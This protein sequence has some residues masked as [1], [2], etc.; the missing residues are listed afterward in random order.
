MN[1]EQLKNLKTEDF[2]APNPVLC[3]SGGTFQGVAAMLSHGVNIVGIIGAGRQE[4]I[5]IERWEL[6]CLSFAQAIERYGTGGIV[7]MTGVSEGV[8]QKVKDDLIDHGFEKNKIF[9]LNVWT[10]LTVPSEKSYCAELGRYLQF[11]PTAL[12]K[13]C[14]LGVID[15]FLCEWYIKDR[16]LEKSVDNFL[17]KRLYY[18]EESKKG[19]IPLRCRDCSFLSPLPLSKGTDELLTQFIVSDHAFC[20]ADCVYCGDACSIPRRKSVIPVEDRYAGIIYALERLQQKGVLDPHAVIQF[21]GGEIT[22]NPYKNKIYKVLKHIISQLPELQLQ[23]F[24]NCFIYDQEI[25]NILALSRLSF[26]QCDLDAGTPETYI[27]VKGFHK[28]DTVCNN[29]KRYIQYGTVKLKYVVLPGWNDS[30][31]D[32]EGTIALL[33]ELGISELT[34]SPEFN[35]SRNGSRAE[36]RETLYATAR[37]IVLLEQNKIQFLMPE[38]FWKKEDIAVIQR[39]YHELQAYSKDRKNG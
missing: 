9:D 21:A 39:L 2:M 37:F 28:F 20:N 7:I 29:L 14:N 16:P 36:I 13:C 3:Y 24:S 11:F 8:F 35:L 27:K 10:W 12:S 17:E 26:L 1:C 22:I 38:M 23:I 15:A 19:R 33:K 30:Q 4:T 31:A 32:Y 34:L 18:M 25:A 5:Q 6:P